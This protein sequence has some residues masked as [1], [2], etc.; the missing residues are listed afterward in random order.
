MKLNI[1]KKTITEKPQN[2]KIFINLGGEF[3]R[4]STV[5]V[6]TKNVWYIW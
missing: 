5:K 6:Y 2:I 3:L 1:L 4:I